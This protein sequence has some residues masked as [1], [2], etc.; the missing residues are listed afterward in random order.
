MYYVKAWSEN[1]I[2]LDKKIIKIKPLNK[3]NLAVINFKS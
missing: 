1:I 3:L 2:K